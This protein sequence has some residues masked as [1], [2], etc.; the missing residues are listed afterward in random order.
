MWQ[1][2]KNMFASMATAAQTP[3]HVNGQTISVFV[4]PARTLM[5]VAGRR[6]TKLVHAVFMSHG[7]RSVSEDYT[8]WYRKI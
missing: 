8:K 5:F 6:V 4:G 2:P 3:A 1:A 7:D